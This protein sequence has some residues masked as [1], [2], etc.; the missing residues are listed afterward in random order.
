MDKTALSYWF[1]KIEAAGVPVPKTIIIPMPQEVQSYIIE[2]L[3]GQT[4]G[5][6][7]SESFLSELTEAAGKIG[8]PCFLRTDHTSGKH[9]W[10]KTCFVKDAEDIPLHVLE[11]VEF[12]ECC[13]IIGLP[14]G[15]WVIRELLPTLPVG[16]C[17]RYGN[18]PICKEF[19]FFV[20]DGKV[21][22]FHPYWPL[23]SLERG[24]MEISDS[25]I[26]QRFYS[27]LCAV[28]DEDYLRWLA[29]AAGSAVGGSWSVDIL[30]TKRGWF[31]TDMAE[32][33]RSFHWEGCEHAKQL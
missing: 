6:G 14:W 8:L 21:R 15:V 18:M 25:E 3:D 26:Q 29:S 1:P 23:E 4:V 24:G 20:D 2:T 17:P 30:K 12:S 11:L 28:E 9:Q 19:R 27:E 31:V 10:D 33:E 7:L 32:A 5:Q 16:V 13:G 22:C